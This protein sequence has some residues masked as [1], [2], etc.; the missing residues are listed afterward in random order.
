LGAACA[1]AD[2]ASC[3]RWQ[4]RVRRF[5]RSVD[6]GLAMF[7]QPNLGYP[8]NSGNHEVGCRSPTV[9]LRPPHGQPPVQ[10]RVGTAAGAIIFLRPSRPRRQ[11]TERGLAGVLSRASCR[12]IPVLQSPGARGAGETRQTTG[13][14]TGEKGVVAPARTTR[15]VPV[16]AASSVYN[17]KR[18]EIR[19][20]SYRGVRSWQR[21]RR[22]NHEAG[23][24]RVRAGRR[25]SRT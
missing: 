14:R 4:D 3:C 11:L 10:R 20:P 19:S 13:A 7:I 22:L 18:Q 15:R 24:A 9:T 5:A 17:R 6:H 16:S 1:T 12:G 8:W 2:K 23:P 21:E 25:R